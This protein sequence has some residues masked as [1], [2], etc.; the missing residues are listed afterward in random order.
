MLCDPPMEGINI[1]RACFGL[2]AWNS[3]NNTNTVIRCFQKAG[4]RHHKSPEVEETYQDIPADV[5]N[6]LLMEEQISDPPACRMPE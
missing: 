5:Q 6:F 3:L 4:F 1:L 2:L